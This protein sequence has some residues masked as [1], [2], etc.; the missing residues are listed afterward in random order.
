MSIADAL[1]ESPGAERG[2]VAGR[3]AVLSS[4]GGTFTIEDVSLQKPRRDEILVRVVGVGV[5][6]T[7]V[8]CRGDFPMPMPVVL[9]HEGAGIVEA[10]GSGV[11]HVR[12]GDHVV[13]SFDS[14]GACPNC[15][16]S[17]PSYC[18]NFMASNFGAVRPGDGSTPM[19]RGG[20]EAV[21]A[22]FF[23]QSSFATHLIA[24]ERNTVV[25]PKQAPLE[26]LGPLGCGIQ[27]GAGSILNSLKVGRGDAVAIFGAGAV[28]LSAVMA[29][30][31]AEAS[32]VV[33]VEPNAARRDLALE[34]GAT[35]VVDPRGVEDV[36]AAV[37]AAGPGG[38]THALD[39]TG[40]P[41]VI[42]NAFQT[43]LPNG[44]LGFVGMPPP[45]AM[46]PV[47]IMDMLVR[48]AGV[49]AYTEGD[50][51]PEVFIP[52]LVNYYLEGRLPFDRLVKRYRF[53]DINEAFDDTVAGRAIK[54]VLVI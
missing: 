20:G 13:M 38:V 50:S 44:Q 37:K 21:N 51:D 6:H 15:A 54:P 36:V 16:R 11:T 7:D 26:I 9:G 17:A 49:K 4:P 31:I 46:L 43:L 3:A 42:G 12:P 18:Y 19:S 22:R 52:Q 24:R 8:V 35:A 34:L 41:A 10:V 53:E 47:N 25:V 48:G 32:H 39:T 40:I 27:T 45:D 29:A 23:G 2:V 1:R 5:C 14:C 30:R 33:V 28:G